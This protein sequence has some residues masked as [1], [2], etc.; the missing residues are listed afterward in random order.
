ME[1]MTELQ[2]KSKTA[3]TDFMEPAR[4]K[5]PQPQRISANRNGMVATAHFGATRAGVTILEAG[6]NAM[7]AA[8]A[9]AFALGVCEPQASGLGGQTM[10]VHHVAETGQTV[11]IDGSSRAP[12]RAVI[13]ASDKSSR[14]LGYGATT[15][16][17]TPA[18]LGY[19]LGRYGTLSLE[20]VL[21]P[22]IDLAEKGVQVTELQRRLQQRELRNFKKGNAGGFFLR[23]GDKPYTVGSVFKQPVLAKTYI[24]LAEA[25]IEDF[26]TGAIGE[27]ICEDMKKNGGFIQKDDMANIPWPIEREPVSSRFGNLYVHTMPPP[28]AGRTLL[29]MLNILRK[30]PKN[31][32]NPDTPDGALLLAEVI[33]RAQLDRRDRPFDPNFYPQVQDRRMVGDTY[34]KQASKQILSRLKG[35]GETTH[36]SVMDK[37]GNTVALTQSIERVYGAKVATPDLGFLY[38]NYM[39]AFDYDDI[40]HPYYL[41]PNGVPWASVAPTIIFKAKKP[42]LAIGS[43][44]SERITSTILQ[45]IVRLAYQ[46]PFDA[47]AAPRLHCSFDGKVSLEAAYMRD[48]IPKALEKM[49]FSIDIREPMSFYLGCIQMVL[50][51]NDEFIGVADPRRDGSA[52]GPEK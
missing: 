38:N 19:V 4:V 20:Q 22:A 24:R 26:Y 8:V 11:A 40:S 2:K 18:T 36:L 46:S 39:S 42:W 41:R 50:S 30:F 9:A 1:K 33:R 27:R 28:A 43:P 25:G 49:G 35:G 51:E 12:N 14:L 52:G 23:G 16:P 13:E 29:Q 6:G 32:R 7:D 34:A 47:V 48:D 17:S 21:K 10:M 37:Q 5:V 44:G 3:D 45:I 31:L 15:V